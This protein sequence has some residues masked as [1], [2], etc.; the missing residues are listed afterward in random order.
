M[1]PYQDKKNKM[2]K[3]GTRGEAVYATKAQCWKAGHDILNKALKRIK[4]K[5]DK[6]LMNHG[7]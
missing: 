7:K 6:A 1:R 2:W 5:R 4:A 3:W